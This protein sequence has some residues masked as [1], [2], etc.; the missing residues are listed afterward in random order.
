MTGPTFDPVTSLNRVTENN[1]NQNNLQSLQDQILSYISSLET[2]T[3]K[4]NESAGTPITTIRLIFAE[5]EE[6]RKGK[7]ND[8]GTREEKDEDLKRLYKEKHN[9]RAGTP[10]TTIRLIFAEEEE[11]RKG[12]ENDEGTRE[13]KDEDLKR[14]YKEVLKFPRMGNASLVHDG[15][16]NPGRTS[17]GVERPNGAFMSNSKCPELARRFA[18]Q[19]P[20]T[21]TEMIKRV[22]DFVK[23]GAT[24]KS[25]ENCQRES[26]PIR[27]REHHIEE[28]A[29]LAHYTRADTKGWRT[30]P[31]IVR[32]TINHMFPYGLT[33]RGGDTEER[34]PEQARL[35][36]THTELVEIFEEQLISM[37]KIDLEEMFGSEGLCRR[38]MMKFTVVRAS[39]PYNII[40]GHTRMKELRAISS[41]THA[42]RGGKIDPLRVKVQR[43]SNWGWTEAHRGGH[44]GESS[45]FEAEGHYRKTIFP[46]MSAPI[47]KPAK[48]Q[49]R[50]VRVAAFR[51]D[52]SA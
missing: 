25:M 47:D 44:P 33:T 28:T 36:Q 37:G 24:Y 23:S 50:R 49:Q 27:D 20:P 11:C 5:E 19:A 22:D 30:T 17:Q 51:Y 9:E 41:I 12:K 21:V 52:Q 34:K 48:G 16:A 29:H 10:I 15:P 13:E 40:L 6:C 7:E 1:D 32:T 3:K 38:T 18:D 4:H 46:S 35:T 39:S 8:E 14:L 43:R 2:L 45:I 26:T 42:I 31:T